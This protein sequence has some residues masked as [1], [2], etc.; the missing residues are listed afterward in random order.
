[1]V[2]LHNVGAKTALTGAILIIAATLL[3]TVVF[4][5]LREEDLP[6]TA[7]TPDLSSHPIY[8][9][10][11]FGQ[12]ANVIDVGIQPLWLP[13]GIIAEAMRHDIIL[14]NALAEQGFEVRFHSF[15]KGADVNYFLQ[16]GDLEVGVA[17]DMPVLTACATSDIL[18][19]TLIQRGFS[20][21]VANKHILLE[22]LEGKRVGYAFGSNAHYALLHALSLAGLEE[23]DVHLIP[24]DVNEMAEA[25]DNGE[26]D[27]FSAWEPTPTIATSSYPDQVVIHRSLTSGYLYFSSSLASQHPEAVRQIVASELRALN[28]MQDDVQNLLAAS[29]WSL[30]AAQDFSGQPPM[31][32]LNQYVELAN[33]DLL[34]MSSIPTVPEKD[35][36]SQGPLFQELRF[37]QALGKIPDHLGW[38]DVTPCFDLAILEQLLLETEKY[39]LNTYEYE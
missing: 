30:Q 20:C 19:T 31:L 35:L 23:T 8:S 39:Q 27:A 25:L 11:Q 36:S 21:I 18:I 32:T 33:D 29:Q 16:R 17:G 6:S 38:D 2:G 14:R 4:P 26:I 1:M 9:N 5:G 34:G 12:D 22:E 28:W 3:V 15:L 10:Y 7:S 24:L 37:L 13:P